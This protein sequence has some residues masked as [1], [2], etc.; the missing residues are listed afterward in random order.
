MDRLVPLGRTFF[1]LALIGLGIEHFLFRDFVTGRAPAWPDSVPGGPVWAGATGVVVALAG[2]AILLRR[3]ARPAAVAVAALVFGWALLRHLPVLAEEPFLSGAWTRAGKAW[4]LVGGALA[5]AATLPRTAVRPPLLSRLVD[6]GRPG[7][8]AGRICLG[9]FL[10]LTGVQ[11]FLFTQFVASLIP[12]WFPGDPVFWTYFAA[13]ALIAGGVG[14]LVPWTA[15]TAALL[16]GL[17]VFSWFWIVHVPRS[18]SSVSDGIAVFEALA[19]SGIAFVLT[20]R[21]TPAPDTRR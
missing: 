12:A 18:L 17:M 2:A 14:L 13:V 9:L 16:S 15:R 5:V 4:T 10:V 11:H 20:G 8:F 21:A 3:A 19:V 7:T 1:A 6:V